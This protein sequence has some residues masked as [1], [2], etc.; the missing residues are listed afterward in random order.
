MKLRPIALAA[1]CSMLCATEPNDATR[2]WWAHV[3]AM[4]S[5]EMQ[6]RDT[7]T[8][9]Y[10]KAARYVVEQFE[11]NG[12]EPAGEHG[13]YQTV[14]LHVIRLRTDES[15]IE[16]VRPS[17]VTKLQ[18]LRQITTAAR[19]G[20]P[21]HLEA[22]LVFGGSDPSTPGLEGKIL[23]QLAAP[24][25]SAAAPR[26]PGVA[27]VLSID[28]AA[29]PEPARWPVAYAVTMTI[30]CGPAVRRVGPHLSRAARFAGSRETSAPF[31]A[32]RHAL[33]HHETGERRPGVR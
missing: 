31:S 30:R 3:T 21:E 26:V 28:S 9:S 4:G 18:W 24:G 25:R 11:K 27:G 22:P 10:R 13:Y 17:G 1:V 8:E 20:L 14:P 33:R 16:L 7:G 32:E 5:D 29:G 12:L 23:V 15:S 6:G 2:R 19:P